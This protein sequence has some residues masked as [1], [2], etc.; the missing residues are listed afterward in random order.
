MNRQIKLKSFLLFFIFPLLLFPQLPEKALK[1][2]DKAKEQYEKG[3][4]EKSEKILV[5]LTEDYDW[6]GYIWGE[7]AKTR[8]AMYLQKKQTDMLLGGNFTITVKDKDGKEKPGG[9]SLS[10]ALRTL[11]MEGSPSKI[12]YRNFINTCREGTLRSE[13]AEW[14]SIYI[15]MNLVDEK[16]DTAVSDS[17]YHEFNLAEKEFGRKNY[18]LAAE[19][20]QKAI[21]IDKNFFKARLYL[22]DAYYA[23]KDYVNAIKYFKEATTVRPN[24]QEGW[25][26]L[27]DAYYNTGAVDDA[28]KSCVE[29]ILVYPDV[30]MF[31][32]LEDANKSLGKR[33]NRQWMPRKVFPKLTDENLSSKVTDKDW[34]VYLDALK[35]IKPFCNEKGMVIKSNSLSKTLYADV[36]A[37]EKMVNNSKSPQ[38]DFARQM[39]TKG[40]FDCYV[41]FSLYHYDINEQYRSFA[42]G[43][44]EKLKEY[45]NFLTN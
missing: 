19:H 30:G 40:Y 33:F 2:V 25:K 42:K 20:Y 1:K 36:Y 13:Y 8:F 31:I 6:S 39:M 23:N 18:A 38:F 28:I 5:K 10:N 7:L 14:C 32:K 15:R 16:T 29:G 3:E 44:R 11:L 12:A 37:F 24:N 34:Q 21:L 45:I 4:Y 41:L 27:T 35:E 26:Y 22:G 9:D 17:A 43:N